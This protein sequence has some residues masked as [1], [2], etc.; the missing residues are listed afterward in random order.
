MEDRFCQPRISLVIPAK[1][2]GEGIGQLVVAAKGYADEIIVVD[3]HSS[4]RTV[5]YA[6]AQGAIVI[7]DNKKGKGDAYKVGIQNVTGDIIVFMDADGSHD[8]KM[9]P[10]LIAPL[11]KD[12]ADFV[13]GSRFKGGSD[14]WKGDISTYLRSVGSGFLILVINY[15]WKSHLT[16]C[17]NGFR[18]IKRNAAMQLNLKAN[19]FDIEQHMIVQCLKHKLRV[20]EVATHE[21]ERKWGA[22]KLPTYRKSYLF[23][24]RLFLDLING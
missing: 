6:A 9:I 14:E 19:D 8:P 16:E 23:F 20:T 15:R 22:S 7:S 4:D 2:E 17:L 3:G 1:N 11:V 18:A 10:A 12:Q 21:Y 13:I 5:D 24:W